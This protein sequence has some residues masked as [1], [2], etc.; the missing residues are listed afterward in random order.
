MLLYIIKRLILIIPILL[1]VTIIVFSLIHLI[2]GDPMRIMMGYRV[3]EEQV[4]KARALYGLDRPLIIQYTS[5]FWGI[6]HGDLGESL[7]NR[8]PVMDLIKGR[9][10]ATI[11]L[12]IW[13]TLFS[14][15]IG[16]PLGIISAVHRNTWKDYS[17]SLIAFIGISIPAFFLGI[18]LIMIFSLNL[19][20]VPPT[21]YISIFEDPLMSFKLMILPSISVG[22]INAAILTRMVRSSMLEILS[23]DYIVTA[24][25][26]GVFER[27]VLYKHALRNAAIPAVTVIGYNFGY[28][29]GG[30]VVIEEVF[31]LPGMGRLALISIY[32]RDYPVVQGVVLLIAFAFVMVNLITDLIYAYID[33]RVRYERK[34]A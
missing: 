12:T 2:P 29:L 9:V 4:E 10:E 16:I 30:V 13:G 20:L 27:L 22:T 1:G 34:T 7:R 26:K 14:I 8:V 24:R 18:V 11:M 23:K 21:G 19:R 6:L 32:E 5:Y 33:P 3:S 25:A 17:A 15:L 28:L 31:A